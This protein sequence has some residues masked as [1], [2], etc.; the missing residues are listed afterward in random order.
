LKFL[1]K[2]PDANCKR[3]SQKESKLTTCSGYGKVD[4]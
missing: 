2:K 4:I 1:I 3:N